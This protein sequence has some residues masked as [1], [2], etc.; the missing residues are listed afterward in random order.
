MKRKTEGKDHEI[1]L[2]IFMKYAVTLFAVD[3]YSYEIHYSYLF[4][5]KNA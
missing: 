1:S 5:L 3:N 4:S 2:N